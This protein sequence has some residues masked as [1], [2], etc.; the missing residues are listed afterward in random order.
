MSDAAAAAAAETGVAAASRVRG[1]EEMLDIE[2]ISGRAD[3]SGGL[4][5]PIVR[6]RYAS[7]CLSKPIGDG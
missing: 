3:R 4:V 7:Y 6:K 1:S 5:Q 2:D